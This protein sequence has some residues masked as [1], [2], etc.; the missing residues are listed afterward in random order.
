MNYG[1][2]LWFPFNQAQTGIHGPKIG[3]AFNQVGMTL[4]KQHTHT[5]QAAGGLC[6]FGCI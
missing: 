1:V 3:F 6:S 4:Q 5:H 2:P